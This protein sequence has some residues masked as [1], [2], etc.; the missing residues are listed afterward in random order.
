MRMCKQ[1]YIESHIQD[2][3]DKGFPNNEAQMREFLHKFLRPY[4]E[5]IDKATARL[6]RFGTR[7]ASSPSVALNGVATGVA[8]DREDIKEIGKIMNVLK[9]WSA[10]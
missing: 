7:K 6:D 4:A 2:C 5:S 8:V 10:R 9:G 3:I 1:N